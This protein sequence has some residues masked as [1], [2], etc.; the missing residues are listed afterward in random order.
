MRVLTKY[1]FKNLSLLLFNFFI[2]GISVYLLFDFLDRVDE[3][4][5][6]K[7]VIKTIIV[8]FLW[9][10]PLI[11]SQI[12][13]GIFFL[14]I[15]LFLSLVYNRNEMVALMSGGIEYK[16]LVFIIFSISLIFMFTHFFIIQ[17]LGSYG[18]FE[19][20]KI[21]K[22]EVRNKHLVKQEIFNSW[23]KD[24]N[25]IIY[26]NK[27][28]LKKKKGNNII[29]YVVDLE[30]QK[31]LKLY[32]ATNFLYLKNKK[33]IIL[34]NGISISPNKFLN[35]KYNKLELKA[36]LDFESI[37]TV[38]SDLPKEALSVWK[39]KGILAHFKKN[40]SNITGILTT[41]YSKFSYS[42]S[43]L[44][45]SFLG[46]IIVFFVKNIYKSF[47]IGL[48]CIFIYYSLFVTGISFAEEGILS[49]FIGAWLANLLFLG[50]CISFFPIILKN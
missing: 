47:F 23:V 14:S 34:L 30:R 17:E 33:R 6:K 26:F 20:A 13:P 21:W 7:V 48:I 18:L 24:K 38:K 9:K 31:V 16:K 15:I 27:Y 22:K 42:F 41:L 50:V 37:A 12:S 43:I 36:N 45:L 10:I 40:G 32:Y 39:L 25:K 46:S 28:N 2:A 19:T 49:P 29:C 44:I 1:T 3:F 11:I 35:S 5:E 4:I 8:Y